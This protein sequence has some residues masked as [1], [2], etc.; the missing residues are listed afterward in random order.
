MQI[1]QGKIT[2]VTDA[3][4]FILNAAECHK[5]NKVIFLIMTEFNWKSIFHK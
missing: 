2:F 4:D 1:V 5:I 3:R